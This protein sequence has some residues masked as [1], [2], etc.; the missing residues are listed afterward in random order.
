M[1]IDDFVQKQSLEKIAEDVRTMP[2]DFSKISR[3]WGPCGYIAKEI[4]KRLRKTYS[5]TLVRIYTFSE[6]VH[7]IATLGNS[8][9]FN[10]LWK[11]DLEKR[12]TVYAPGEKYAIDW[13][14][15]EL[16]DDKYFAS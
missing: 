3:I 12:K 16:V 1:I 13:V 5:D 11:I 14:K 2:K 10:K 4:A 9:D 15:P 6:G 8:N 7:T